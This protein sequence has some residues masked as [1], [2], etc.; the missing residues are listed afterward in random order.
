M[1]INSSSSDNDQNKQ[2]IRPSTRD[3]VSKGPVVRSWALAVDA[4][5]KPEIAMSD[6]QLQNLAKRLGRDID[7]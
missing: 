2:A 6:E 1:S 3:Q 7:V 4:V 5:Q